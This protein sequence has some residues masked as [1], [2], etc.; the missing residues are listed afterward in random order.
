MDCSAVFAAAEPDCA[1]AGVVVVAVDVE[2]W[3]VPIF[4][5]S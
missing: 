5:P 2:P 1:V 4:C 3:S